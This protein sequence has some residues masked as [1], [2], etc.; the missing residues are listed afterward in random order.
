[1]ECDHSLFPSPRLKVGMT[2]KLDGRDGESGHPK[3]YVRLMRTGQLLH[4]TL[5]AGLAAASLSAAPARDAPVRQGSQSTEDLVIRG[6]VLNETAEPLPLTSKDVVILA[7]RWTYHL[8]VK[9][10]IAG[11]EQGHEIVATGDAD[12]ALLRD[13]DFIFHLTRKPDGTYN[14]RKIDRVG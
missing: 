8:R 1:V 9:R 6:R 3:C 13:R 12:A 7:S 4:L 11:E 2:K 14:L 10:V 5:I